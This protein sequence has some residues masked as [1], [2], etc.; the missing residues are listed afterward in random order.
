[1]PVAQ[2]EGCPFFI[3][4][5]RGTCRLLRSVNTSTSAEN[6]AD[7]CKAIATCTFSVFDGE[8]QTIGSGLGGTL[9]FSARDVV[10]SPEAHPTEHLAAERLRNG[11]ISQDQLLHMSE[12][13]RRADKGQCFVSRAMCTQ[14]GPV[15]GAI[16][17]FSLSTQL[18]PG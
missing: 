8:S 2:R 12:R 4:L 5:Q 14:T 15:S 16:Q 1:M 9:S 13:V 7:L 11:R 6:S 3:G 17:G 10:A 18:L